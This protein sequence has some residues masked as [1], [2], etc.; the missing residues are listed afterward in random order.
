MKK[1]LVT[2]AYLCQTSLALTP[3]KGCDTTLPDVPFPGHHADFHV[4]YDDKLH[5]IVNRFYVLGLP[6]SRFFINFLFYLFNSFFLFRLWQYWTT[7]THFQSSW[8]DRNCQWT[9]SLLSLGQVDK[10][11]K[12]CPC[13]ASRNGRWSKWKSILELFKFSWTQRSNLRF[14]SWYLGWNPMLQF[15]STLWFIDKL[16]LDLLSWW[17]RFSRLFDPQNFTSILHWHGPYSFVWHF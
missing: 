1:F 2:F 5:G 3:S 15:L 7:S 14:G 6:K 17:H 13:F 12:L 11:R 16:W 4:D 10:R 9:H 8:M